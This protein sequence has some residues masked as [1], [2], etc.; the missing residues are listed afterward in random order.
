MLNFVPALCHS[1][2]GSRGNHF[3]GRQ[4]FFTRVVLCGR[5]GSAKPKPYKFQPGPDYFCNFRQ[6]HKQKIITV[7]NIISD[8]HLSWIAAK[9]KIHPL[10]CPGS[11]P[12]IVRE[13]RV[14]IFGA[15]WGNFFEFGA[16]EL[17]LSF[18]TVH[19]LGNPHVTHV[20]TAVS[21]F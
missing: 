15:F 17:L 8:G 19:I 20:T 9:M 4:I 14:N 3:F 1:T 18:Y 11:H 13:Q 16:G 2:M 12:R 7:R 6:E 10:R 21:L 5:C